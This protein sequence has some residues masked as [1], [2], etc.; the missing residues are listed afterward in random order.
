MEDAIRTLVDTIEQIGKSDFSVVRIVAFIVILT[1]AFLL[2]KFLIEVVLDRAEKFTKRTTILW[3]DKLVLAIRGPLSWLIVLGIMYLVYRFV[4]KYFDTPS[5]ENGSAIQ[6][7]LEIV[8]RVGADDLPIGRIFAFIMMLALVLF[9]KNLLTELLLKRV[10]KIF[11]RVTNHWD[12]KLASTIRGPLGWLI[13]IGGMYLAYTFVSEYFDV[14]L[15]DKI[16]QVFGFLTIAFGGAIVYI[17]APA[18]GK[19]AQRFATLT[20]TE[21]DDILA[22]YLPKLFRL[23]VVTVIAIKGSEILLGS[24]AGALIGLLGGAGVAIGLV[25]K[26]ILYD[27]CCTIVV[28]ADNIYR[29]GDWITIS[30]VDGFIQ[31]LEIGLR[32]TKLLFANRGSIVKMPNS[33][34]ID[35]MVENWSRNQGEKPEWGVVLTLKIDSISTEQIERVC[36]G[37]HQLEGRIEGLTDLVVRFLQIEG[38]ARVFAIMG[39]A[40]NAKFYYSVEH[41]LNLGILKVLEREGIEHLH[42]ALQA[43]AEYIRQKMEN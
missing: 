10:E 3:D 43:E 4:W 15:R 2:R 34:M 38:N 22:P 29:A 7:L 31:V 39:Y 1:L 25:L 40:R 21:L 17:I 6:I 12:E 13:V 14:S 18:L 16:E 26:D 33:K 5:H 32:T 20:S 11:K 36:N 41:A 35:G 23:G 30:G 27:W 24:S 8:G 28:Y 42:V 19:T 9:L 37:I